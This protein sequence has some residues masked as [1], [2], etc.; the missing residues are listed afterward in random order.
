MLG[1]FILIGCF[2]AS[3][4]T[5]Q[6]DTAIA[7]IAVRT[8]LS[9]SESSIDKAG[10]AAQPAGKSASGKKKNKRKSRSKG[11]SKA[12]TAKLKAMQE[13]LERVEADRDA[14]TQRAAILNEELKRVETERDERFAIAEMLA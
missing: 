9:E 4:C 13:V 2:G 8:I 6:Q 12:T 10:G 3:L 7:D 5:K 1:I 11:G 14:A